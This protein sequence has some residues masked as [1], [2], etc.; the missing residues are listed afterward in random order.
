MKRIRL[1]PCIRQFIIFLLLIALLW[2][3]KPVVGPDGL[4]QAEFQDYET[5][6]HS[7][8]SFPQAGWYID[9]E[10]E[11]SQETA[12]LPPYESI[13]DALLVSCTAIQR[14]HW[15]NKCLEN[16]PWLRAVLPKR[17]YASGYTVVVRIK[18]KDW[19]R[20]EEAKRTEHKFYLYY[21][22]KRFVG[23][24]RRD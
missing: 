2:E 21:V 18:L 23:T 3:S 12:S 15:V 14:H 24:G 17:C 13:Q 4:V 8:G 5:Q 20:L 6:M 1:S 9:I 19:E 10:M 16:A 11:P 22:P 7:H